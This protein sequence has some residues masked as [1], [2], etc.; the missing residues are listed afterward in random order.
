MSLPCE[1]AQ[2]TRAEGTLAGAGQQNR[3]PPH[4]EENHVVDDVS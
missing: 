3:R 1:S 4:S 2:R